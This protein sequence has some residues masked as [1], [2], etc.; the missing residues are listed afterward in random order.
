MELS[1]KKFGTILTSRQFGKEAFLAFQPSLREIS[2]KENIEIDFNGV[3]SLSPSW[4]DEFL[5]PL[6]L[7]RGER[8]ILKN[9]NN[10][11]VKET[12]SFLEEIEG[13][14]FNIRS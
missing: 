7:K 13:F 6:L 9:T 8:L 14:K 12:L 4:A 11:S 10:L 5:R 2:E 1:L 3:D